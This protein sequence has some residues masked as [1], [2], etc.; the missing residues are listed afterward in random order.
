[1]FE[2]SGCEPRVLQA[3]REHSLQQE[4]S[5]VRLLLTAEDTEG[6]F[7]IVETRERSGAEPPRHVHNRED[8]VVVVLEG[9]V[10]FY[11]SG[12]L[13]D[14]PAGTCLYLPRGCEHS[15][16]VESEEAR[17]LV[18]VSPPGLEG[19]YRELSRVPDAADATRAD[20]MQ[21]IERLVTIA[22]RYGVS[23]TGPAQVDADDHLP[24]Q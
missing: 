9:R 11:V 20:G 24:V 18:M 21:D 16:T 6:R 2:R 5:S 14:C 1:M 8:E 19:Y 3:G 17:L 4:G 12:K 22:A 15:F 10:C 13:L 23:I 7:A